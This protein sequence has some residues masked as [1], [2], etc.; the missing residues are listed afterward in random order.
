M[1]V[2]AITELFSFDA[3]HDGGRYHI[4]TSPLI[5]GANQWTGF[6]MTTASVIK[7]LILLEVNAIKD[8]SFQG[9]SRIGAGGGKKVPL[10][11]RHLK[12]IY[13]M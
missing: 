7:G 5:Y 10:P 9:C 11:L 13:N 2:V 6:Y 3:F 12:K 8:R 4:E 1:R